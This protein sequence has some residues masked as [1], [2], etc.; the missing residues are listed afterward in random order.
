MFTTGTTST[1]VSAKVTLAAPGVLAVTV[2]GPPAVPFAVA[3]T[4]ARPLASV[5]AGLPVNVAE[6]PLPG[7]PKGDGGAAELGG[8]VRAAEGDDERVGEG[9]A[10]D[11]V[12]G[13]PPST[14]RAK[15]A[16]KAPMSQC[17]PRAG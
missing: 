6:A 5:V 11:R 16:S 2:Y 1:F 4:H 13:V 8:G 9:P 15:R 10:D 14:E 12:C 3:V 17:A 7:A